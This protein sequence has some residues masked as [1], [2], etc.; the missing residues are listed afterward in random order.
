MLLAIAAQKQWKIDQ[1]D[2]KS[3]FLN[4]FLNEEIY[5]EKP[6][7]FAA[8]GDEDKVYLLKKALYGLK[9]DPRAWYNKIDEYLLKLG[10]VKSFSE[11]TL[12]VKGYNDHFFV[13]SLYVDDL[14]VIGSNIELIQ[15]F[16]E[17]MIRVFE[18]TD[19]GEMS[20]F[21]GIKIKQ[22]QNEIFICQQKY[23]E[24]ILKKFCM[25]NCKSMTTHMCQKE[26]LCKDDGTTKADEFEYRSLVGCLMYLT[27][28]RPDIM[29]AVSV[30]SRFMNCAN[31]S[32]LRAAKRVLKY[33]KGTVSF[34]VKFFLIPSFEL[35]G[36]FD[37]DWVGSL[38]D[39]KNIFGFCFNFGSR[40]FTWNS[41]K[42]EIVAQLTTEAEFFAATTSVNHALWLIKFL[43]DLHLEQK[44]SIEVMVDNQAAIAISNNLVFHGK[45]KH[46]SIKLLFIRDV[47]KD[48]AVRLKYFKTE[49]QLTDIFTKP[50]AKS[51]FED[52]RER[53]G[54]C[55]Y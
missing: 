26:K 42:Q 8:K 2:V 41:K 14:L 9:Q 34:G 47:Q 30:L 5:F 48:G 46:F 10:F 17:D 21:L 19:L 29:Y 16:K 33:V 4:D 50:L 15:Q 39:M 31:E 35:Q 20:Y 7:G 32:H 51:I 53:L 52:L 27:T 23:A 45:T 40:V 43:N 18:M 25:G 12:Y 44:M 13:V 11:I 6:E 36:Y 22:R 1:L 49:D 54:I 28:T 55:T 37:S 3:A 38:D 24:E